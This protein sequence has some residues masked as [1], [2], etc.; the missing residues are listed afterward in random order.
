MHGTWTWHWQKHVED[1]WAEAELEKDIQ[2]S[3]SR[4]EGWRQAAV[5]AADC[6]SSREVGLSHGSG[7]LSS[8][9]RE[10]KWASSEV[11]VTFLWWRNSMWEG[12]AAF[13]PGVPL[14]LIQ[15]RVWYSTGEWISVSFIEKII[16]VWKNTW[17]T[18][19]VR[20]ISSINEAVE[21][22]TLRSIK[23]IGEFWYERQKANQEIR[24]QQLSSTEDV[25]APQGNGSQSLPP[26]PS[27][28]CSLLTSKEP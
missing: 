7:N 2:Q 16:Q 26:S 12:I 27:D 17:K 8:H 18:H 28:W 21:I 23:V 3:P 5:W 24:R 19:Q 11:Q 1:A 6:N 4:D 15:S 13:H 14:S 25:S 10:T 9:H 22:L 20:Q